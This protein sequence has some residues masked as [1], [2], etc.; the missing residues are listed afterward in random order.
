MAIT[1]SVELEIIKNQLEALGIANI[2]KVLHMIETNAPVTYA[3][4]VRSI[5]RMRGICAIFNSQS[6]SGHS[7]NAGFVVVFP[8]SPK[9]VDLV[10]AYSDKL[11]EQGFEAEE[12]AELFSLEGTKL[13][14][15]EAAI[16]NVAVLRESGKKPHEIIN[17]I[18]DTPKAANIEKFAQAAAE[19]NVLGRI[20][21]GL[22]ANAE[23]CLSSSA[24]RKQ[25]AAPKI[26]ATAPYIPPDAGKKR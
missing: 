8:N 24:S 25:R 2:P 12:F 19:A 11:I 1:Q 21:E 23:K 22:R 4:F 9:I 20:F 17:I 7:S 18:K 13:R 3:G 10:L 6:V 5:E 26:E 16:R 15:A 14:A